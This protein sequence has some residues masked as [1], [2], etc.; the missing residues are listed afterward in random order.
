MDW[1]LPAFLLIAIV[2]AA[3]HALHVLPTWLLGGA[4]REA[5][6]ASEGLRFKHFWGGTGIAL[7]LE[8]R[9]LILLAGRHWK[10]HPMGQVRTWE[11]RVQTGGLVYGTG[12]AVVAANVTAAANNKAATGLFIEVR[13]HEHP[14]WRV[15]FP[16]HRV[17][18][19]LSRWM[20]L[21]RQAVNEDGGSL[22]LH[23]A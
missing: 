10:R 11:R 18:R 5:L 7:D 16:P 1:T 8:R 2:P 14:K 21:L 17:D 4:E 23:S 13:D 20:E 19:E 15:A 9:E 6:A 12:L 3:W 22:Q